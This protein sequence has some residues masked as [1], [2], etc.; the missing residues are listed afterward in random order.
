MLI[1]I[2][3]KTTKAPTCNVV[4]I[5]LSKADFKAEPKFILVLFLGS[6]FIEDVVLLRFI[7]KIPTMIGDK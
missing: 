3:N 6:S 1:I 7:V 5:P 4:L 2:E